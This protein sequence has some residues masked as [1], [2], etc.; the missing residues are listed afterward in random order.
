[1]SDFYKLE[2]RDFVM[3]LSVNFKLK[4]KERHFR[5]SICHSFPCHKLM[6]FSPLINNRIFISF[7]TLQR[8]PCVQLQ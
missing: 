3:S 8:H 5:V 2:K 7:L 6:G 1:M 4:I